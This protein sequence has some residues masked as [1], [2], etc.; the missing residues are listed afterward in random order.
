[1]RASKKTIVTKEWSFW[2]KL[3]YRVIKTTIKCEECGKVLFSKTEKR[4][5]VAVWVATC[6]C[7]KGGDNEIDKNQAPAGGSKS[8]CP[9]PVEVN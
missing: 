9:G 1:M 7:L 6:D 3:L 8:T 4:G 5:K 2:G